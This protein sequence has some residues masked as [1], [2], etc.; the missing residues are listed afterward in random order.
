MS[1]QEVTYTTLRFHKSSGLQN[2]VRPEETQ[3]PRDVGHRECSVPWK[4]IVIVL[5]ILCF[6]LLVT[7]AVLVIHIFRD[8]QEKHEQEKTL[9]N[10]RQEYQ[11]MKNDSSLMEEMLR[12]KSSECKAL[13]DS[14]HYL[15]RE[16]NR[17]LRKTKIVLDCS[18]N[19]GKQ[20]EGYW[21]CCG[22][23]CYYFIMDDKKLK[24]CKQ[25][26]QAYNLTLLK[27]NDEDELKFLKSQLQRNTYWIALTHHES[28]EESQ[29]IGDRPSKPV[30]A[31]RNSVPNREKCAYLNSFSTEEDDRARNHGCICEKRLNKFPIPGSCAKGRTQSAL[32]RDEDES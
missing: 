3:R 12:N 16:Q 19:K 22:M 30:S 11:V 29:Q 7:V 4:F 25:I 1:E 32:Q 13:N 31:A 18:Q 9:N 6:L 14:L 10:L 23:K 21:F 15:N 17:C 26:C 28:K 20:V 24:G 27:T 2:P 8:G 5:G